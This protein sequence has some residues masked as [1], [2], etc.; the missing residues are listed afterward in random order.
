[1]ANKKEMK[2]LILIT[3][4]CLSIALNTF[5]QPKFLRTMYATD[6]ATSFTLGFSQDPASPQNGSDFKLYYGTSDFGIDKVKY[7][8][9]NE[10]LD[11]YRTTNLKNLDHFF[12]QLKDLTPNTPYYYVISWEDL[13]GNEY[14]SKRFWTPTLSNNPNDDLSI[15]AGGDSRAD[16]EN[17]DQTAQSII[18]RQEANKM[19]AKLRPHLIAFGGDFTF[20]NTASEWSDWFTDWELTYTDDNKIT[21]IVAAIG[22]HEYPPFGATDAG[23]IVVDQMFDVPSKDIYYALNFHG[24]LLRLYT[25][26]SEMAIP[27]DQSKWLV[28]DLKENDLKVNWKMAQ[29]H[30]PIR[31][32][33]AG[34]SDLNDAFENWAQPFYDY[35][36]RLVVESD[37]H[38]VKTTYPVMPSFESDGT[39]ICGETVDHNF[40]RTQFRGTTFVGEGTWAALRSGNDAKRWT[41][42]MGGFNQVKWIWINKDS[43]EVRTVITFDIED[44]NYVS[45]IENLTEENRFSEPEG[46]KIWDPKTSGKI[47]TI[48][49]NGLTPFV[50]E[51]CEVI[52]TS[53]ENN[54]P[55]KNLF[56]LYPN[57]LWK[58]SLFVKLE[59][60]SASSAELKI[61]QFAT[62]KS[63]K[64]ETILNQNGK[65]FTE[66]NTTSYTPGFYLVTLKIGAEILSGKVL[67][68]D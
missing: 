50:T 13:A 67:I 48:Y 62:G 68:L 33:E 41:K 1:M 45:D 49:E 24:S 32:H 22:N 17:P 66:V 55:T 27:G 5:A 60:A 6:P 64:N 12:F 43:I 29:Y 30:K 34:K 51:G 8:E 36:V 37:A 54:N 46:I 28:N 38:V 3:G 39:V 58:G 52:A 47:T 61:I 59:N 65:I 21:P 31:P 18:I 9:E 63:M 40:V 57:P 44:E 15:I 20:A 35:Q 26:N 25:L 7:A 16:L 2:Q 56:T 4:I 11:V 53:I 14:T 10:P 42:D 23:S 19:V